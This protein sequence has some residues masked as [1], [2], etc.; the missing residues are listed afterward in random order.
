MYKPYWSSSARLR[1]L[2]CKR[3]GV[4]TVLCDA[5]DMLKENIS[6]SI[7]KFQ[8]ACPDDARL[9]G[10]ANQAAQSEIDTRLVPG[11]G[12][13]ALISSVSDLWRRAAGKHV[14]LGK[15]HRTLDISRSVFYKFT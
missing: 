9:V 5:T 14:F 2:R 1:Y 13:T 6:L 7:R 10:E 4:T 3:T 11:N 12:Q 8:F 15:W